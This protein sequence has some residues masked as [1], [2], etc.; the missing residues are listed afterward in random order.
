MN[1]FEKN[2]IYTYADDGYVILYSPIARK[3][4]VATQ[5]Q[6]DGF[7]ERGS[8]AEVF[9]PLADYIPLEKQHKV[10]HPED[11]TL[12]T[13]LPNN[14]CNFN[15][16]Y[17]YS[18]GGRNQSVIDIDKLCRGIDYFIDSKPADFT[19]PLTIS[20]MGGGEP[21][22]SWEHVSRSIGYAETKASSKKLR[23]HFRI[24]TNGSILN[25]QIIQFLKEKKVEVSVSFE[26]LEEIQNLQRKHYDLVRRNLRALIDAGI[27]VQVNSTI[28][29]S[30]VD[31]MSEMLDVL[32]KDFPEVESAMFEP[33][34]AQGLFPTPK[35]MADFYDEYIKG[36]I[37][38]RSKGD[39]MGVDIISF[40]YLRTIFPLDRTCPGEY[41]LTADG[42]I[43][44]CYCVATDREPLFRHTC[45]G[46][47]NDKEVNFDM[48]QFERLLSHNVYSKDKCR[49]CKVKWNCGG[50][51]FHLFN[52]YN[53][54]YQ[55][56]VCRFT[57]DFI[58]ALVIY[59][60]RKQLEGKACG[61]PLLLSE[62]F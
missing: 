24:I 57:N 2:D 11:Y 13:V 29:P 34:T 52:S 26:I 51:C 47:V 56:E 43:T 20:Y 37:D 42:F 14:A 50:G 58:E 17:C 28:T 62:Q 15:C 9:K 35:D 60:V 38:I 44:G 41:C 5:E 16:S 54:E 22:L 32:M 3:Y 49:D 46:A 27:P 7:L 39:R 36:F 25:E 61:L 12:L 48:E 30:N 45:Y 59:K 23:L 1:W 55:D 10:R 19:K 8:H 18:A 4:A 31:R 6:V 21:L 40:S 33:V 53:P